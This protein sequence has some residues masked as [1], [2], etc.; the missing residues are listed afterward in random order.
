MALS[1]EKLIDNLIGLR[2][3]LEAQAPMLID[4]KLTEIANLNRSRITKGESIDGSPITFS[5]PRIGKLKGAYTN[6]YARIKTKAGGQTE[7]VDLKLGPGK[8]VNQIVA[9]RTGS[10]ITTEST[11]NN[12]GKAEGLNKNYPNHIGL[13]SQQLESLSNTVGERFGQLTV[14]AILA[15]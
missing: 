14:K 6:Q 8:Y 4:D 10:K 12:K 13:T 7:V 3:S 9:E 11:D 15:K 1:L 2:S 5:R